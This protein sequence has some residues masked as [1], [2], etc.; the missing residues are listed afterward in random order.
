MSEYT[1]VH[2]LRNKTLHRKKINPEK[3]FYTS[4]FMFH[5]ELRLNLDD[6]VFPLLFPTY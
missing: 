2:L 4:K 1:S 5:V 6:Q 3:Q